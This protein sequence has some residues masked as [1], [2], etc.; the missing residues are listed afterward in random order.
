MLAL[1]ARSFARRA[2]PVSLLC[3]TGALLAN[4]A[5]DAMLP[6]SVR[7]LGPVWGRLGL[8][9][10]HILVAVGFLL[11]SMLLL[12]GACQN[13][14]LG[15]RRI[16]GQTLRRV[17]IFIPV[18]LAVD[19]VL[20]APPIVLV[21]MLFP[22]AGMAIALVVF[23]IYQLPLLA[24]NYIFMPI[25]ALE[26]G[27]PLSSFARARALI[28][29]HWLRMVVIAIMIEVMGGVLGFLQAPLTVAVIDSF[30]IRHLWLVISLPL[31]IRL[32]CAA[33]IYTAAYY[34]LRIAKDGEPPAETAQIFD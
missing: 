22:R 8:E 26:S 13:E 1:A 31:A 15:W 27:G 20:M 16:G 21:P 17:A 24:F 5:V 9:L 12:L 7:A 29:G 3:V 30:G 6:G 23:A 14:P 2:L 4:L 18:Q 11:P 32:V 25:L 28:S 33:S 19:A 34:R 10:A